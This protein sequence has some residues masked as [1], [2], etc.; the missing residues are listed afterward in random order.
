MAVC[1]SWHPRTPSTSH[2]AKISAVAWKSQ[3]LEYI[4][5]YCSDKMEEYKI[6]SNKFFDETLYE[7]TMLL[8]E[9]Y[10]K[11]DDKLKL[12]QGVKL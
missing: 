1:K 3:F 10:Y 8:I 2:L 6:R 5:K 7:E 4:E 11:I 12:L 9:K